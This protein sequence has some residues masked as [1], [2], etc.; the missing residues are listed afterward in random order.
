MSESQA[1]KLLALLQ[2][3][4]DENPGVSRETWSAQFAR[5]ALAD[6]DLQHVPDDDI[7]AEMV[8]ELEAKRAAKGG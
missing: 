4:I 2:R 7:M 8:K 1:K 6:P 5:E 3:F